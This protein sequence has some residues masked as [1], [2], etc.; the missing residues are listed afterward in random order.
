MCASS[1]AQVLQDPNINKQWLEVNKVKSAHEH[2]ASYPDISQRVRFANGFDA[3]AYAEMQSLASQ[4]GK[5]GLAKKAFPLSKSILM[6][7]EILTSA[8]FPMQRDK[9]TLMARRG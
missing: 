3:D 4:L 6:S 2:L 8:G 1:K 9:N 5:R 7:G